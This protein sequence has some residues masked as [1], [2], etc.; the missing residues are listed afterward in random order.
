[1]PTI[2]YEIL[3]L[4]SALFRLLGMLV[5]GLGAGWFVLEMFRK[6]QQAWQLQ[7]A[8]FLGFAGLAVAAMYFLA[9]GG[10][11]AFAIGAGAAMLVWGM[12]KPKKEEKEED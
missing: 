9:P 11:G 3:D 6:G 12:K 8:L 10:L 4:F 5:F 7:I 1:M 2:V